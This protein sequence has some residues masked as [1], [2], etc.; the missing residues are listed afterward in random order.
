MPAAHGRRL[1]PGCPTRTLI[2][3][4]R[5]CQQG[6]PSSEKITISSALFMV[7]R[8]PVAIALKLFTL[9]QD[10]SV[11]NEPHSTGVGLEGRSLFRGNQ[12][13]ESVLGNA[14]ITNTTACPSLSEVSNL[15]HTAIAK[16]RMQGIR[17]PGTGGCPCRKQIHSGNTLRRRSFRPTRPKPTRTR[18]VCLSLCGHGR[19]RH[20]KSERPLII[21][22]DWLRPAP[23]NLQVDIAA[24]NRTR[25][26]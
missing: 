23:H 15:D 12:T 9:C 26:N 4:I 19:K 20:Y 8:S 21:T 22:T 2:N 18:G 24:G 1:T 25:T 17:V 13:R 7:D 14:S 3:A 5:I 16:E 6:A 10:E 11:Q